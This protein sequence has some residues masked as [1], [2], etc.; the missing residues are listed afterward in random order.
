VVK[1][2][3]KSK[4]F[5]LGR[6]AEGL[7]TNEIDH[8]ISLRALDAMRDNGRAVLILGGINKLVKGDEKR[9]D[10][11]HGKAKREFFHVLYNRY[12]VTDHFTVAGEL[13]E[14]QGAGYPIDVIA[15]NGRGKS[16][17]K[18]VP[19]VDVPPVLRSWDELKEKL[20]GSTRP[21]STLRRRSP[22]A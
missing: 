21:K 15:I 11:Y 7:R 9:S 2:G 19:S 10:A 1:E 13:Y 14:K 16:A 22:R 17:R 6:H 3:D 5:D 18:K 8:V 4:R 12:N 20:N